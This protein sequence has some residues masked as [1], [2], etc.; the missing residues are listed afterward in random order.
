M[1]LMDETMR[2]KRMRFWRWTGVWLMVLWPVTGASE[3]VGVARVVYGGGQSAVCFSEGFLGLVNE[4]T[5]VSVGERLE[6]VVLGEGGLVG[7]GMAVWTGEGE[8]VLSEVERDELRAYL[9]GGG[10]VLAS[11]GCSSRKW[12]AGFRRE[13]ARVLPGA[14]VERLDERH[15]VFTVLFD[16]RRSLFR[17]GGVRLP[18][19][20]S[21]SIGGRVVMVFSPDG[22]NDADAVGG[23]CCCC[24]GDE[25]K[26]A[27]ELNANILVYAVTQ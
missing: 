5:S 17:R 20:W 15:P 4:R 13:M 25:V 26:R 8:L 19:L 3:P 6:P 23:E 2:L 10:F 9:M 24:G 27:P 7:Y 11:A 14:E 22:L 16:V 1:R 12:S 18:E 21:V